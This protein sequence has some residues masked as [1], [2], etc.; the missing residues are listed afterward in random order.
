[1]YLVSACLAGINCRYDGGNTE[2]EIIKNMVKEGRAIAVC[3]EQLGE[4]PIPRAC[5]EIIMDDDGNKKVMSVDGEDF[6]E[7]YRQ[8]AVKTLEICRASGI[9]EAILQSRSPSCGYGLI[10]DGTFSGNRIDGEGLTAELLSKN[11]IRIYT[12]SEVDDFE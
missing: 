6:T 10:Y 1:M 12:E 11:N 3:P 7:A 2:N 8:G 5:C 4:L 9:N